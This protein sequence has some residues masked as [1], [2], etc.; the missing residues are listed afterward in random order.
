MYKYKWYTHN[1]T[2]MG[3]NRKHV[4]SEHNSL[5]VI[6]SYTMYKYDYYYY[7]YYYY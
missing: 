2:F 5:S 4:L 6:D 1:D 3:M 7:Y